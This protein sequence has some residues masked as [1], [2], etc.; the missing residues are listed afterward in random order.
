MAGAS[1]HGT[2]W[3]VTIES[4]DS[5]ALGHHFETFRDPSG[6]MTID[7]ML[8]DSTSFDPSTG[9]VPNF[10]MTSDT[11]WAKVTLRNPHPKP[12]RRTL[13][14]DF[15][16]VDYLTVY[17]VVDGEVLEM[18]ERGNQY[19]QRNWSRIQRSFPL[20]LGPHAEVTLYLE[21]E[22][23]D[24]LQI[25]ASLWKPAAFE[26]SEQL[27][28]LVQGLYFGIVLMMVIYNLYL[29]WI[30]KS[31]AYIFY[32]VFSVSTMLA[33]ASFYGFGGMVL[34]P[35]LYWFDQRS[36][37]LFSSL[38]FMSGL[39][40][41]WSFLDLKNTVPESRKVIKPL[42]VVWGIQLVLSFLA[43]YRVV[44]IFGPVG[45]FFT[46]IFLL[47]NGFKL[48]LKGDRIAQ[49][50]TIAWLFPLFG[51]VLSTASLLGL[52]PVMGHALLPAEAGAIVELFLLSLALAEKIN[53]V[54]RESF[55][56]QYALDYSKRCFD[57]ARLVQQ[58][59]LTRDRLPKEMGVQSLYI[60]C[61][62]TGGDW[63]GAFHSAKANRSFVCIGDIAGH[64]I[65]GALLT[66]MASG[67]M[68]ILLLSDGMHGTDLSESMTR[69]AE[70][71]NQVF[72]T[73]RGQSS[74]H[75]TL[76]ML[77]FDHSQREIRY[78][79]AGHNQ[80]YVIGK[81][82]ARGILDKGSVMGFSDRPLFGG[83][84]LP[85][86]DGIKLFLFTDGLM[87]NEGPDGETVKRRQLVRILRA[88][89]TSHEILER[90]KC[91]KCC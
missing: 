2:L 55:E 61:D 80:I 75:M 5:V 27:L 19:P 47:Y 6:T 10:G 8:K 48:S 38:A 76:V 84:S 90:S 67:S 16:L 54:R 77:G 74:R 86:E 78:L 21:V 13:S 66:A 57:R 28:L 20:K 15:P 58:S 3:A 85:W 29:G 71:I 35:G 64:G 30:F 70:V 50:F 79:N 9:S 73:N 88:E 34:W 1:I 65:G 7:D 46:A 18:F 39:W 51:S 49:Y 40:F 4:E 23:Q 87:E 59:F 72:L 36:T 25:V 69:A 12:V 32:S 45:I 17:Y 37:S 24:S 82:K 83:R 81:G 62:E 43:P 22:A 89:N 33:F 14:Y 42:V 41:A 63:Y 11:I 31:K 56:S 68:R 53:I 52:L 26:L 60:P 91:S 44:L